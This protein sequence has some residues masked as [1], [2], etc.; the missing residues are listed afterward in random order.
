MTTL[1]TIIFSVM[2]T[3][4]ELKAQRREQSR[5]PSWNT[6]F[7]LVVNC[8]Q[9]KRALQAN[10]AGTKSGRAEKARG[11]LEGQIEES[12]GCSMEGETGSQK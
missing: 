2:C 9:M 7:G 8:K 10:K 3:T 5:L 4:T 11:V 6:S 1:A 12:L